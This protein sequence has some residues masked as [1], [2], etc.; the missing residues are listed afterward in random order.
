[1]P[2]PAGAVVETVSGTTFGAQPRV[3][4]T[5]E[6]GP[7]L[8]V[9]NG[10]AT[11]DAFPE[12]FEDPGG[13]PVVHA[14]NVYLIYWD[15]TYHYHNDWKAL[16]DKFLE[17]VNGAEN[18]GDDVFAM[19][20]QYTDRSGEPAYNRVTYRGSYTDTGPYPPSECTDP[21]PLKAYEFFHT[22]PIRCL[23]DEQIHE[24]LAY[25]IK[26][27]SLPTG[28]NTIYYVLTPPG[29][30]V[31]L[32]EGG[33]EGHCSSFGKSEE[34]YENSF[35]SYHGDVN[36]GGLETGDSNTILYGVI[37][38]TA[39]GVADGQL[40]PEDRTEAPDCQDGGFD[41]SSKP[42]E[43]FEEQKELSEAEEKSFEQMNAKEKEEFIIRRELEGPHIQEPNQQPCPTADGYC[44]VGLADLII[45]QVAVEQQNIVTDP[46]LHSWQDAGGNEVTDECR[47]W[48]A[49]ILGGSGSADLETGAGTLYNNVIGDNTYYLGESFNLAAMRLNFPGV[50]CM[51]GIRL[52]PQ[53]N[54]ISPVEPG[55]TVGFDSGESIITL[56]A[57]VKY[58][59]TGEALSNYAKMKW[60]FG[61]GSAEVTG[62]APGS[63]PC[64]LPWSSECAESVY[65]V[66]K[67]PGEYT[68]TLTVTDV[69]G[70][71]A[72]VSHTVTVL[73]PPAEGASAPP[74][75]PEG[76]SGGSSSGGASPAS[77]AAGGES[78][79]G[80][81]TLTGVSVPVPVAS[82]YVVSHSLK[83]AI[84]KGV[85]V[86]YKVNEQVAGHFEVLLGQKL[87]KRLKIHGRLAGA[88]PAG[89]EPEVVIG[90]A[91][92]V[93]LKGGGSTTH[94]I[95]TKSAAAGLRHAKKVALSLRLT[96]RNA[97]VHNPATAIV[98]S[99]FTLKR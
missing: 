85:A 98:M 21:N 75:S 10:K 84:K 33:E 7:F 24:H 70:N 5:I 23:T 96:I 30:G 22:G 78:P 47:S 86:H 2:A 56:D 38:W 66:F 39:G 27:W 49:P 73:G 29:V 80:G 53:F 28:M 44:D 12:T 89:S 35:C 74:S 54:A 58:T 17:N 93:T 95:L 48:F 11:F 87:A 51:P 4:G 64:E 50:F 67:S 41:P 62:Y 99:A 82:A 14:S 61:D 37:P 77:T 40:A 76:S 34:S 88:L 26:Q 59:K 68:V 8:R 16:I 90:T 45:N 69:G 32:D 83:A 9:M 94:V 36:P 72:S 55:T 63:E 52:E 18:R 1:M 60:S 81:T 92:V 97:A 15:P 13:N 79:P 3:L 46:L 42:P 6:D 65:H 31:C 91:L 20:T 71:T 19:D 57:G 25:F 43:E